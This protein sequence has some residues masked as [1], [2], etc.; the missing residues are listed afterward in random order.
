MSAEG[1]LLALLRPHQKAGQT[2]FSNA[3]LATISFGSAVYPGNAGA[4][5]AEYPP[6]AALSS[7]S[8]PARM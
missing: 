4:A 5:A 3:V 1:A 2:G 6:P 8:C 7:H